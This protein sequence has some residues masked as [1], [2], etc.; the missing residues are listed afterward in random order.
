MTARFSLKPVIP[1]SRKK[2]AVID[3]TY[4]QSSTADSSV[5]LR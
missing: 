2:R 4:S 3:R 5:T 1:L